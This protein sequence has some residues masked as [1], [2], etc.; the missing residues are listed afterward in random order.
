M[1]ASILRKSKTAHETGHTSAVSF[2]EY[3]IM[4]Y[5]FHCK[6]DSQNTENTPP[7]IKK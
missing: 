1:D 3:A 6:R 7:C 4:H 5:Y 2:T